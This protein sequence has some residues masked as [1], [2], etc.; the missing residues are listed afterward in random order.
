[1]DKSS[2]TAYFNVL[3]PEWDKRFPVAPG[4]LQCIAELAVEGPGLRIFDGACGTGILEPFLLEHNPSRL[5]AVDLSPN[6][7]AQAKQKISDPRVEFCCADV[8]DVREGEF[9]CVILCDA[10]QH[11]ENRGSFIRQMHHLILPGG[12]LTI[13]SPSG[14]AKVNSHYQANAAELTM[15][16][17][18]AK[19]LANSLSSYFSVDTVIDSPKLYAVS[20]I[21][22][23]L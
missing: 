12:R 17:P 20:G 16:L 6:M 2:L 5:L 19:T 8:I 21:R 7:I 1:M 23:H 11:F 14:R 18:A 10:F 22:L 3:A 15:P 4:L 9:D 13:C